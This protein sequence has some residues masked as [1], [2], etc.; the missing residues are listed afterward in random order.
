VLELESGL[1]DV[2]TTVM[3]THT[4]QMFK[5][6]IS[7]SLLMSNPRMLLEKYGLMMTKYQ[8]FQLLCLEDQ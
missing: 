1:R 4:F 5:K 3:L 7:H 6:L 2:F 8:L